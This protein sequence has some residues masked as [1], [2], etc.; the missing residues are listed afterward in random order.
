MSIA[1]LL[2]TFVRST[3]LTLKL[4]PIVETGQPSSAFL[5]N[6]QVCGRLLHGEQKRFISQ[7]CEEKCVGVCDCK[8][9]GRFVLYVCFM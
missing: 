9:V 2:Y 8:Y 6:P 1:L 3:I 7:G 4:S 5:Q